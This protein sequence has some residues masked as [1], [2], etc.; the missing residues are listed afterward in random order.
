MD[1]QDQGKD[2]MTYVKEVFSYRA[3]RVARALSDLTE[4]A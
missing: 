4:E 1:L 3:D 2:L